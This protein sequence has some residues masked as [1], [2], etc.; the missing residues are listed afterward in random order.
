MRDSAL[1]DAWIGAGALRD[2][3]WGE[4]TATGSTRRRSGTWTWSSS[5]RRG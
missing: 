2:L 1:P 3:V 5:T 4:G